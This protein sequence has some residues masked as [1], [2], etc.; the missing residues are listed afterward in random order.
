[1]LNIVHVDC[2]RSRHH[3]SSTIVYVVP[4]RWSMNLFIQLVKGSQG[5]QN[6]MICGIKTSGIESFRFELKALE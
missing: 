6:G 4:S 5:V 2:L 1:M 3:S